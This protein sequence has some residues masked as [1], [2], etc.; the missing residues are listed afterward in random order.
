[1]R[2]HPSVMMDEKLNVDSFDDGDPARRTHL[3]KAVL[4][5]QLI[6]AAGIMATAAW[7]LATFI[8]SLVA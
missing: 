4:L 3:E 5:L 2:L 7:L 1:M 6:I 8:V